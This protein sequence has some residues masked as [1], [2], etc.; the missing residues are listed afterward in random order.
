MI[1]EIKDLT[2][3]GYNVGFKKCTHC[4]GLKMIV[5]K[6]DESKDFITI[7]DKCFSYE[8]DEDATVYHLVNLMDMTDDDNT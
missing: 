5:V 2:L 4:G 7:A 8:I 3:A 6:D 1:K